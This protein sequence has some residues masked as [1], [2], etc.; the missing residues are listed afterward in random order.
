MSEK[1][2][3]GWQCREVTWAPDG[4]DLSIGKHCHVVLLASTTIGFL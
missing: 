1:P 4:F 2:R 3:I